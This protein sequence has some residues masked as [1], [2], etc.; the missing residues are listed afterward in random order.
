ML[1]FDTKR[2]GIELYMRLEGKAALKVEEVIMNA[3][4]TSNLTEM[5]R[6]LDHAFLPILQIAV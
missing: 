5:W 1:E 6:A 4:G 3:N 2:A